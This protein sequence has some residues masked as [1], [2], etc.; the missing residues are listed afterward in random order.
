MHDNKFRDYYHAEHITQV[1]LVG[2]NDA[3]SPMGNDTYLNI[4]GI[5]GLKQMLAEPDINKRIS[6]TDELN[7]N[8]LRQF[9]SALPDV[10]KPTLYEKIRGVLFPAILMNCGW[11]DRQGKS[12][13]NEFR[14]KDGLQEW[15]FN[16]FDLWGP[17]WDY[18]WDM[19]G[20]GQ[21]EN[22]PFFIAQLGD[23]DEANSLPV[24]IPRE[25]AIRL[26]EI[27][28]ETWG[29]VEVSISGML[30][31]R[32]NF[33]QE[34]RDMRVEELLDRNLDYCIWL[35]PNNE[36]H[37]I[38]P[39]AGRTEIYSGYLWKCMIPR[40]W[41]KAGRQPNLDQ[42]Y[43]LWEHTNFA[44]REAVKY[45]LE[46][47]YHKERYLE[48]MHGDLVLIQKSTSIVPG[49]PEWSAEKIYNL[50]VSKQ[51]AESI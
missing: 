26:R 2:S 21:L 33:P 29:G 38:R 32:D 41:Y 43:Y 36:K 35:D 7:V 22:H 37:K 27:F 49:V 23:N 46:S 34:L 47:L 19:D 20:Q 4:R 18:I 16:G 31:H 3:G 40:K 17:S 6:N 39:L 28:M 30:V 11:W 25:K 51:L 50:L 42:V 9:L 10:Q 24:I 5:A 14:W 15:L 45:N 13:L 12:H 1:T 8:T 48:N 44:N